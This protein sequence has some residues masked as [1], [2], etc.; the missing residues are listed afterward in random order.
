MLARTGLRS[1]LQRQT[2]RYTPVIGPIHKERQLHKG[3][4][5]LCSRVCRSLLPRRASRLA[6]PYGICPVAVLLSTAIDG[7]STKTDFHDPWSWFRLCS[8][9]VRLQAASLQTGLCQA[10]P[11]LLS[12]SLPIR[13]IFLLESFFTLN[14]INR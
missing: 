1:R 6:C 4:A 8:L 5:I 3:C 2:N 11:T 12:A 14:I 10:C 7:L 9:V 13:S